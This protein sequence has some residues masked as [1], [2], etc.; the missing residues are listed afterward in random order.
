MSNTAAPIDIPNTAAGQQR[1]SS[2]FLSLSPDQAT[3]AKTSLSSQQSTGSPDESRSNVDTM[4]DGRRTSDSS[5][6]TA[7]DDNPRFLKL[8]HAQPGDTDMGDWTME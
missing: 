5:S 4:S 2:T 3:Q 6:V 7:L 1:R 8:G